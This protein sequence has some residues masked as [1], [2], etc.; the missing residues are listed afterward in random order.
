MDS[1]L[2][3]IFAPHTIADWLI[4]AVYFAAFAMFARDYVNGEDQLD[5]GMT[6]CLLML[7]T[8]QVIAVM[9]AG[10]YNTASWIGHLYALAALTV[11][12]VRLGIEFSA[13]YADA[14]SR[15]EH[16]EAVHYISSRLN[17]T[18]D[19]RI[20]L[21]TFVT[22]SAKMLSARFSSIMLADDLGETLATIATYGLLEAPMR[23][24]E[25]MRLSGIGG[26]FHAGHTARAFRERQ[27]CVV[28]DIYTDVEFVPWRLLANHDGYSVSVPLLHHDVV[29]GVLNMFF[30]EHVPLNDER[31]KLFQTLASAAA[32]A[33]AN[34]QLYERSLQFDEMALGENCLRERERLAS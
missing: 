5:E 7:A 8:S 14:Q 26:G 27:I 10:N 1:K 30:E 2:R 32:V 28:D 20:V 9:G 23:P 24:S 11:L 13:S 19:L 17:K 34:A 3:G 18:L 25:P 4:L 21:L 29:L 33:I 16:L 22:D 31:I 6:N 15:V 12:L